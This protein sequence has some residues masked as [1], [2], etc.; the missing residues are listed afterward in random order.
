MCGVRLLRLLHQKKRANK[1]E[2]L[3]LVLE[4][5]VLLLRNDVMFDGSS[6]GD[7]LAGLEMKNWKYENEIRF[8]RTDFLTSPT[9][10]K[11]SCSLL[12]SITINHER[13]NW[14]KYIQTHTYIN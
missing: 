13:L 6:R 8:S 2:T 10:S 12:L 4:K 14:T 1:E 3:I 5:E 9:K 11:E 7:I